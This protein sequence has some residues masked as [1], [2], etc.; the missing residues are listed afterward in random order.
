M[1]SITQTVQQSNALEPGDFA[2]VVANS[3]HSFAGE[4]LW[5]EGRNVSLGFARLM[6]WWMNHMMLTEFAQHGFADPG[7]F[8]MPRAVDTV[9]IY[10]A[11]AILKA[12]DACRETT[13]AMPSTVY[14]RATIRERPPVANDR[15]STRDTYGT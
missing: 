5:I 2:V 9:M 3:Q 1:Q 12:T 15:Y 11:L 4:V 10:D 13:E 6:P 7:R 14:D 8:D